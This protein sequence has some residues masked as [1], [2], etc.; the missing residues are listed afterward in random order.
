[1][2]GI[3]NYLSFYMHDKDA[4]F[5]ALTLLG[6]IANA[7]YV[8]FNLVIGILYGS[9]WQIAVT[10]YYSL[11]LMLR[12]FVI[13]DGSEDGFSPR[14]VSFLLLILCPPMAGM[15]IYAIIIGAVGSRPMLALPIFALYAF[16]GIF[17]ASVGLIS[18][19]RKGV[20]H[21]CIAHTAR[22]SLA[23][24][25]L[26]NFQLSLLSVLS[27]DAPLRI[28]LN[29]ITGGGVALSMP[30]LAVISGRDNDSREDN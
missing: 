28:L 24:M 6:V 11:V 13:Y 27:I 16:F 4:R 5:N 30:L 15:I 18:Q 22:L 25:S 9:V 8:I 7:I 17:R 21:R 14:T 3:R 2:N 10:A 29:F 12:V 1:M 23:L 19:K 20:R 26:F